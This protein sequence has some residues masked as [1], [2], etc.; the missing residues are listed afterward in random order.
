[1]TAL[2]AIGET[3]IEA[4]SSLLAR[5]QLLRRLDTKYIVSE[6]ELPAL[7]VGLDGEYAALR[8]ST[9]AWAT[10]RS[11]Y[12]DTPELGCFHDHRRGRRVRHK[13]RIRHYPERELTFLEVKSKRNALVTDKRRVSLPYA[14]EDGAPHLEFLRAHVGVVSDQLRPVARVEYRR[15]TLI[16]LAADERVTVDIG[17]TVSLLDGT[18][19]ALGSFAVVEIKQGTLSRVTPVARRLAE[20]AHRER[21]YSKYVAA[22]AR[23]MP[24]ERRNRLLPG[25]RAVER[26]AAEPTT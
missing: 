9:G 21:S 10:Y 26:F 15:M 8:V 6:R 1:V 14:S 4:S 22:I 3:F 23:L 25:L 5:R 12:L 7:L 24:G 17:L 18:P 13:I 2:E 19:E 16:S 11:L 20:A